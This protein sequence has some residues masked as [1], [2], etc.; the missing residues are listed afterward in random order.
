MTNTPK[1]NLIM[2]KHRC[3]SLWTRYRHNRQL[4]TEWNNSMISLAKLRPISIYSTICA[5]SITAFSTFIQLLT[6]KGLYSGFFSFFIEYHNVG[7]QIDFLPSIQ[8]QPG[9][10][11]TLKYAGAFTTPFR[12]YRVFKF[13][14]Q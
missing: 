14:K 1:L 3:V 6:F 11:A 5:A 13:L 9:R 12:L 2:L 4:Y 10:V 8:S 7:R